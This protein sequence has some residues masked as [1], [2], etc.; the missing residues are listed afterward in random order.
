MTRYDVGLC[1]AG[2]KNVMQDFIKNADTL[3]R[4][5][6]KGNTIKLDETPHHIVMSYIRHHIIWPA[7]L[8][9]AKCSVLMAINKFNESSKNRVFYYYCRR[10]WWNN[11]VYEY[12]TNCECRF[13]NYSPKIICLER[14]DKLDNKRFKNFS[15]FV[16]N[17][18]SNE[19]LHKLY[20]HSEWFVGNWN[21]REVSYIY[22][23]FN[24]EIRKIIHVHDDTL[25]DKML[26]KVCSVGYKERDLI[27]YATKL[28]Q[29][30]LAITL[31]IAQLNGQ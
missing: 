8:D 30:M 26:A 9:Q 31:F 15:Q 11:Q 25:L 20:N 4:T 5:W 2:K 13:L 21:P 12:N 29:L 23:Q 19:E 24:A 27:Q 3:I 22:Q 17:Y 28:S 18:L 10:F 6:I 7:F 16:F 14:L 1:I